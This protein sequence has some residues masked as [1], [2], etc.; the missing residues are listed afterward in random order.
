[1]DNGPR[2]K[3]L[4]AVVAAV[5]ETAVPARHL[6]LVSREGRHFEKRMHDVE[7][8]RPSQATPHSIENRQQASGTDKK[9]RS[10]TTSAKTAK[11]IVTRSLKS[12]NETPPTSEALLLLFFIFYL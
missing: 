11:A 9:H 1:M 10:E 3:Q 6:G 4:E 12:R 5:A 8:R 7:R 2:V